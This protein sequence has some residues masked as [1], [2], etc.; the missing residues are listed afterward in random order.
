M[1]RSSRLWR[2]PS[3]A[4]LVL[5][6][7]GVGGANTRILG[8]EIGF[9]IFMLGV[10]LAA[11]SAIGLGATAAFAS[12]TGRAWRR[13]ALLGALIPL[14]VVGLILSSQA[15][16][17]APIMNDIA[18][19]LDDPPAFLPEVG[20]GGESLASLG[21]WPAELRALQKASYPGVGPLQLAEGPGAGFARSLAAARAMPDWRITRVDEARGEIQAVASSALFRFQ[22]D[23]LIRVRPDGE[24]SRIDL[25]SRSRVGRGDLGANAARI[26]AFQERFRALPAAS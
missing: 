26:L 11:L 18:T 24:G 3:I 8:P 2:L 23:V 10:V 13:S 17:R 14:G 1:S 5:L 25:R 22:D 6:G 19:D 4:V 12:A 16:L 9:R 15:Q 20:A 21:P 7:V